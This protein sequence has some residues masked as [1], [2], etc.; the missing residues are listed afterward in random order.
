M[1]KVMVVDDEKLVRKSIIN[2]I[3]WNKLGLEIAAEADNGRD[4]CKL[5]EDINPDIVLV[6]NKMP[7][8]N[9]IEFIKRVKANHEGTYFIIISGYDD[10]EYTKEAIKTGVTDYIKKPVDEHELEETLCQVT[11]L[12]KQQKEIQERE[13]ACVIQEKYLNSLLYGQYMQSYGEKLEFNYSL[14]SLLL[15]Y[16]N[17]ISGIPVG[18]VKK[19]I[20]GNI[21]NNSKAL[22]A[23]S[24]DYYVFSN[25][26]FPNEIR[27]LINSS[28][29]D[30]TSLKKT[31]GHVVNAL[32]NLY[33][34]ETKTSI[35]IAT[36][37]VSDNL[38][39]IPR[40]YSSSLGFLKQKIMQ[41]N[42]Y[43]LNSENVTVT[44][45]TF[46]EFV[47]NSIKTIKDKME[48]NDLQ[49]ISHV[50]DKIFGNRNENRLSVTLLENIVL[51]IGNTMRRTFI[52][53]NINQQEIFINKMFQPHYLLKF[54]NLS[55]LKGDLMF[56]IREFLG[57][58]DLEEETLAGKLKQYVD[59][60]YNDN[61]TLTNLA[62]KFH[63][64]PNYLSQMF[65]NKTG[66]NLSKYIENI[67][68]GKAKELLSRMQV[69]IVDV[70]FHVGYNDAN[71]F[72]KVFKKETG[73][74]PSDYHKI[75]FCKK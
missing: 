14:F 7:L 18:L 74:S 12:L 54:D 49:G 67:R 25:E 15:V 28:K 55:D 45:K 40:I 13:A 8:M 5:A 35:Y 26:Q 38:L 41:N 43:I 27:I 69:T 37:P 47:Y 44:D 68:I 22:P 60:H 10:F 72:S 61:L 58:N 65:K 51:E 32:N 34:D 48:K 19:M 75:H 56:T 62:E 1:Y 52:K 73:I 30:G 29:I 39:D 59:N 23:E 20:D 21:N 71:Y 9:G 24:T 36:G 42:L 66:E 50:L 11:N 53:F 63:F 31:A 16:I 6:D 3:D 17:R 64:N 33:G 2:R 46:S 57:Y 4:A 70:A